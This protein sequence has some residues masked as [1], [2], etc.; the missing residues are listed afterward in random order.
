[1]QTKGMNV[2]DLLPEGTCFSCE[3]IRIQQGRFECGLISLAPYATCPQCHCTTSRIHSHYQRKLADLP[4]GGLAVHLRLQVRKFFC[5]TPTCPRRIFAEPLPNLAARYARRTLRLQKV[6]SLLGLI[7]GGEPGARLAG[8]LNLQISPDT[9][10]NIAKSRVTRYLADN[11]SN[12]PVR[13]LGVDEWAWRK[14]H[15][16]GTLLVDL[17]RRRTLDLLP[18]LDS[19]TLA[20]WLRK[21]PSVEIISRDR[22]PLFAEGA[23]LGAPQAMQVADRWHLLK[24]LGQAMEGYLSRQHHLLQQVAR[25]LAQKQLAQEQDGAKTLSP[26]SEDQQGMNPTAP[27]TV[28]QAK[29][30]PLS[31]AAQ[32]QAQRRQQRLARYEQVKV[33]QSQ[34]LSLHAIAAQVGIDKRTVRRY[35]QCQEFP[36]HAARERRRTPLTPFLDYLRQRWIEGSRNASQLHRELQAQGYGGE[37]S[38]VQ[39]FVQL[40]RTEEERRHTVGRKPQLQINQRRVAAPSAKVLARALLRPPPQQPPE[41]RPFLDAVLEQSQEVRQVVELGHRFWTMTREKKGHELDDWINAVRSSGPKEFNDFASGLLQ[42]EAA[43][44]NGLTMKWS[45]GQ[46]E[47]QVNRL[48]LIKRQM[49]GR[50]GFD[51]LRARVMY[52]APRAV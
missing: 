51:L 26:S 9:L 38:S 37:I 24:N 32:Q 47:G 12:E 7:V 4:C 10:L 39:R 30:A 52:Q 22:S 40:W 33:L 16:Y 1:M 15:C 25:Q 23:R 48:K 21:H 11:Q 14:G 49:Y 3:T 35:V 43:V 18:R 13:V 29:V 50:A 2:L 19:Q 28:S 41:L 34:G 46:V 8:E 42:D 17:E 36:E 45:N 5:D 6:Y 31:Q 44:R 20:Q 27:T